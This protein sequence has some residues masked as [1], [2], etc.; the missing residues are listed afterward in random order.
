MVQ[1]LLSKCCIVEKH[2]IAA[3]IK[4]LNQRV[5]S[6]KI[7]AVLKADGYGLGCREMALLCAENGLRSFAVTDLA[8]AQSIVATGVPI[9]ELL[10]M[11][12]ARPSDIPELVRLGIT[13]TIASKEDAENLLPYSAH[14]H[15]KIDTGMGRRGIHYTETN[16]I[17]SIYRKSENLRI[18]GIYTHFA[19]PSNAKTTQ[20]QFAH[21]CSVLSFLDKNDIRPGTRHCCS[22][23]AAFCYNNML[24][25]G[26]RVGSAL[27]GRFY[28]SERYAFQRTCTVQVPI[29]SIRTLPKGVNVGYGGLYRTRK[30]T[31]IAVCPIGIHNGFSLDSLAG[32]Q[33]KGGLVLSLLYT[34]YHRLC[35]T[36]IPHGYVNGKRCNALGRVCSDM[37]ILD[38]TNCT[39]QPGDTVLFDINP[40][41]LHDIPVEFI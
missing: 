34:I 11:S 1:T 16:L 15:I 24:L 39:C 8:G 25:D 28:N 37:A 29:E 9:D 40:L 20:L 7:Y 23:S 26:I 41:L 32:E 13:F 3:N 27:L 30:D 21:F 38:V 12:S 33:R 6:G 31:K 10:L 14:A 2:K 22:S 5:G 35:G 17:A 36:Y 18:T 4:L 19:D